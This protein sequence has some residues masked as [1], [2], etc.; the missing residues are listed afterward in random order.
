MVT[1]RLLTLMLLLLL[2]LLFLMLP[3][4]MPMALS[5][6]PLGGCLA[7]N[8]VCAFTLT[9]LMKAVVRA[10]MLNACK[11][12]LQSKPNSASALGT[13]YRTG[14][15]ISLDCQDPGLSFSEGVVSSRIAGLRCT[16]IGYIMRYI[17]EKWENGARWG[18]MGKLGGG[19]RELNVDVCF[20]CYC[21]PFD[22]VGTAMY[23]TSGL[24]GGGG[25]GRGWSSAPPPPRSLSLSV[26]VC[27]SV[28]LCPCSLALS[29]PPPQPHIPWSLDR[30]HGY[31]SNLL[32]SQQISSVL[33][34]Q[35]LSRYL[36]HRVRLCHPTMGVRGR[37]QSPTACISGHSLHP[38]QTAALCLLSLSSPRIKDGRGTEC[39][40]KHVFFWVSHCVL[41]LSVRY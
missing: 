15:S 19:N 23:G 1:P 12:E 38:I 33:L 18:K 21:A 24:P 4:A 10:F 39:S 34:G 16:Q 32:T 20:L 14:D 27:L 28:C 40:G 36:W 17:I 11:S 26:C 2:L 35:H 3:M 22:T 29:L 7:A 25:G 13:R 41:L 8:A 9:T 6:V 31:C 37:G 5:V 30:P